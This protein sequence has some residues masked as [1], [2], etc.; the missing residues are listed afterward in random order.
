MNGNQELSVYENLYKITKKNMEHAGKELGFTVSPFLASVRH[1][2]N[3]ADILS[4]SHYDP[5]A[6]LQI[7]YMNLLKRTPEPEAIGQWKKQEHKPREVYQK[8]VISAI[9]GSEEFA[10]KGVSVCNN[11]Y[12]DGQLAN[13][14]IIAD[15]GSYYNAT[16]QKLLKL[17]WKLPSVVRRIIKKMV[18]GITK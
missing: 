9:T 4:W 8:M 3:Q 17:Y 18:S 10:A 11:I 2:P 7:A 6:F 15:S 1:S 16:I 13:H 14:V 12:S 5:E